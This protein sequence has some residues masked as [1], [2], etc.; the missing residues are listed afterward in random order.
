M[1][2]R[3][4]PALTL[5]LVLALTGAACGD[6]SGAS[7]MDGGG[8]GGGGGVGA[9]CSTTADCRAGLECEGGT[10]QG[11]G[12][13]GVGAPCTL[14]AEC[15]TDLYCDDDR[16]C[17]SAGTGDDFVA[18]TTTADCAHG[19]VCAPQPTGGDRCVLA[20]DRDLG[21]ACA[22]IQDCLAG[23]YCSEGM[24]VDIPP[25]V[26]RDAAPPDAGGL[27]GGGGRMCVPSSGDCDDG[28]DC[29]NDMCIAMHCQNT[30]YD[31][32]EDGYASTIL[33]PCGLDCADEDPTVNPDHTDYES[34]RHRGNPPLEPPTYD[35]NC[36]GV[37]ELE[38]SRI[39]PACDNGL[40]TC[41]AA[42]GWAGPMPPAC[43]T[44]GT[45]RRCTGPGDGCRLET[46]E[47]RAQRCR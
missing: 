30:L 37:E 34:T 12:L 46:V 25:F 21:G 47:T 5:A 20:G 40:G 43:G 26:R 36:D 45:W 13:G 23:L 33:G 6:D 10:C 8:G 3:T 2:D 1:L 15:M 29:T 4:L 41:V 19:Y 28:N 31:A 42:E 32:D 44:M 24:C 7:D 22:Q 11:A 9:P 14:T 38:E 39:V 35:W 27:D 17:A 16:R 18:C